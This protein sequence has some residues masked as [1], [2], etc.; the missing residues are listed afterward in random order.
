MGKTL[1]QNLSK[2]YSLRAD[3]QFWYKLHHCS[4]CWAG[5]LLP[6]HFSS[7][8]LKAQL[9]IEAQKWKSQALQKA[10]LSTEHKRL[11]FKSSSPSEHW[12]TGQN[13]VLKTAGSL[14]ARRILL[15]IYR[16]RFNLLHLLPYRYLYLS[17]VSFEHDKEKE[18]LV[19]SDSSELFAGFF[20][21]KIR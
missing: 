13:S 9:Y 17:Q 21:E 19:E 3:S 5:R 4:F 10:Q 8:D 16:L 18:T 7:A 2:L 11:H 14:S 6:L 12:I 20:K 15:L 1:I